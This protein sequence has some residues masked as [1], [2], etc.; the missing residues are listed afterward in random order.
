MTVHPEFTF[1]K[2]WVAFRATFG[3]KTKLPKK[4][5]KVLRTNLTLAVGHGP[6]VSIKG[7]GESGLIVLV[8][9]GSESGE[10]IQHRLR[11]SSS[12]TITEHVRRN[13]GTPSWISTID[14]DELSP[15]SAPARVDWSEMGIPPPHPHE[16]ES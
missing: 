6:A 1:P 12:L 10:I 5:M 7:D 8:V 14:A 13:L 9:T 16:K 11:L 15:E 3:K 2:L 4:P